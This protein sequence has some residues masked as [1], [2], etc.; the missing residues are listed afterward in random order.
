MIS[1]FPSKQTLSKL[2]RAY[3]WPP[4]YSKPLEA[5]VG[6]TEGNN[7]CFGVNQ[8][9]HISQTYSDCNGPWEASSPTS[10]SKE[11]KA[12]LEKIAQ[13]ILQLD[14]KNTEEQGPHN[15]S[16]ESLTML[17]YPQNEHFSEYPV[18]NSCFSLCPL[19]YHE[20]WWRGWFCCLDHRSV[21]HRHWQAALWCPGATSYWGWT[22]P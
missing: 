10:C 8:A 3:H 21:A 14:L 12:A 2:S 1:G 22:S 7:V 18:S 16:E 6:D 9:P 17:N 13:D 4:A 5:N 11:S 15:F 19:S 20:S